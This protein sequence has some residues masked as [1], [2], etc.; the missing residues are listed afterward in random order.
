MFENVTI[1]E[2]EQI[3]LDSMGDE[4]KILEQLCYGV[5]EKLS[6]VEVL[7]SLVGLQ[8]DRKI[9]GKTVKGVNCWRKKF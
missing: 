1:E 6:E 4:Y 5:K 9:E 7:F 3:L 2:G 8:R